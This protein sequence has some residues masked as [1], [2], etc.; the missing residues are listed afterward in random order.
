[1][2]DS[3]QDPFI[4]LILNEDEKAIEDVAEQYVRSSDFEQRKKLVEEAAIQY[5]Q[6]NTTKPIT[7]RVK[8]TDLIKIKAK[9]KRSNIPYQTL[10]GAVLHD[11]AENKEEIKLR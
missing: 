1:M 8:Q 5:V 11:F 2:S 3:P 7:L 6:L 9:A 4:G 10:L